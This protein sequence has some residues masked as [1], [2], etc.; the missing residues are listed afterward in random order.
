MD[1]SRRD[2]C[3]SLPALVASAG[4]AAKNAALPS[5]IYRFE[6]HG[7]RLWSPRRQ[8]LC[9][10]GPLEKKLENVFLCLAKSRRLSADRR[11]WAAQGLFIP[12][13]SATKD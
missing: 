10:S 7:K 3:L 8:K 12:L 9:L 13:I 2:L 5:K 4:Y 6:G 11:G 1:C